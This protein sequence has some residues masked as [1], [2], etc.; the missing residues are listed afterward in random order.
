MSN[1]ILGEYGPEA[2]QGQE[3]RATN[4]GCCEP[5]PIPYSP[6]QGPT[7]QMRQGPGLGGTNHGNVGTQGRH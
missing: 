2:Y 7:G 1:D 6:P 4:G 3:P 5:K